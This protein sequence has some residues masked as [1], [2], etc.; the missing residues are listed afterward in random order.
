MAVYWSRYGGTDSNCKLVQ[1]AGF[2][3]ESEKVIYT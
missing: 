1:I 2:V 3:E